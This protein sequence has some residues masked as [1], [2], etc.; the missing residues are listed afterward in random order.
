MSMAHDTDLAVLIGSRICHDLV[1]PIGAIGNGVELLSMVSSRSEELALIHDSVALA[2]ARI[3][4]LRLAFGTAGAEAQIAGHELAETLGGPALGER[5]SVACSLPQAL[6]RR[7][8]R[9][10]TLMVLCCQ[11]VMPRGGQIDL[12]AGLEG[13]RIAATAPRLHIDILPWAALTGGKPMPPLIAAQ[14]HF[15]LAQAALVETGRPL[16]SATDEGRL[17]LSF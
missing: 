3:G 6:P 12:Q 4:L 8:A 1:N 9:L 14:V 11:S 2:Q 17:T 16:Q 10:A 7:E 5:F 13:W 15:A